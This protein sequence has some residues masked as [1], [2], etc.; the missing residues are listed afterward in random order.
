M[1]NVHL[2]TYVIVSW[3]VLST[4]DSASNELQVIYPVSIDSQMEGIIALFEENYPDIQV[5]PVKTNGTGEP[6]FHG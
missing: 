5:H 2:D 3:D 6:G 4:A 1:V